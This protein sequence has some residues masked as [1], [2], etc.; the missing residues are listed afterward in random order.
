MELDEHVQLLFAKYIRKDCSEIEFEELLTWLVAMDEDEKNA[1]SAPL[2]DLWEQAKAGKLDSTTDQINWDHILNRVLHLTDQSQIIPLDEAFPRRIGWR[3]IAAAII[4]LGVV[5]SGSIFF[6]TRKSSTEAV[7]TVVKPLRYPKD[8]VTRGNNAILTLSNG[9]IIVLDTAKKGV[10]AEQGNEK[11][12]MMDSGQL[13]Y[14]PATIIGTY[15][16]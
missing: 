6:L 7:K 15:S 12:I 4:I 16:T 10:I 3:K 14:T 5:L 2:K 9:T 11:V 13:S 1:L 8:I